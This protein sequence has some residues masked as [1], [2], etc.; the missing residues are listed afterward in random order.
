MITLAD[1]SLAILNRFSKVF[2]VCPDGELLFGTVTRYCR[3]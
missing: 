2:A 1:I 3:W